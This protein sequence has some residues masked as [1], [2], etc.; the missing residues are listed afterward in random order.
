MHIECSP[1][2]MYQSES[3]EGIFVDTV[4]GHGNRLFCRFGAFVEF[5]IIQNNEQ[6]GR[7]LYAQNASEAV[8][9]AHGFLCLHGACFE[10]EDVPLN[11]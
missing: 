8:A 9:Q 3:M 4:T 11:L 10:H 2:I 1:D 5:E 7:G 6:S